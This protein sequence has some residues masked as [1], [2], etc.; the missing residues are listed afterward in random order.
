VS[1]GYD[2]IYRL[3]N[4]TIAS[5]P[6]S[7]NGTVS[8]TYDAV[9]NRTQKVS[10]LPGYPGGLTNYNANDQLATDTYDADGNTTASN[11]VG[12]AYDFENRL[13]QAGGGISIMYDGDGNRVSKTVAVMTTTY[14]VDDQNPTGYAQVLYESTPYS[15]VNREV[16]HT[17][18]Y[19]LGEG[20]VYEQR[21]YLLNGNYFNQTMY[22][23]YD[24]HGSVRALTDASGAVTDT[25]D[26]DAFG[27]LIHST[28]TT[29]N[30]YLF[31]GEQ[32][33]PDLNLY[34][35]RARYL[36]TSSGRFF[37]ADT[38]E[39]S[40]EDPGSHHR[41][42]YSFGSPVDYADPSGK[43]GNGP[44]N[45]WGQT[46][47]KKI[48]ADYQ[49]WILKNGHT[50]YTNRSIKTILNLPAAPQSDDI[51]DRPDIADVTDQMIYEIKPK[52]VAA[53]AYADIAYYIGLILDNGGGIWV[54]G[55]NFSDPQEIPLFG[56][57]YAAVVEP[58]VRGAIL[59]TVVSKTDFPFPFIPIPL[60]PD[61]IS[62]EAVKQEIKVATA[63]E[64][65]EVK[66]VQLTA[67]AVSVL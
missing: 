16:S 13:V 21:Q 17:F 11:G 54:P 67:P 25:Y 60:S 3:T 22:F 46:V 5:D 34:Y 15:T 62:E 48:F 14:L 36:N 31:A 37:T 58:T 1:Y 50:G 26:Y 64:E 23:V 30:N 45:I 47:Q 2:S 8:Y 56:G 4:E 27:N 19:G 42:L 20:P 66:E 35:N 63:A 24:G 33:D 53:A 41:Y 51:Y 44:F 38:F 55:T 39:G 28:G 40:S 52:V 12:Y 18:V 61:T 9:G 6:N 32:F 65:A 59:Y 43:S 10:T 49:D 57:T 29:Y 7:V